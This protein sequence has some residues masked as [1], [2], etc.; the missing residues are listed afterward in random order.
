M[1]WEVCWLDQRLAVQCGLQ[2]ASMPTT[3]FRCHVHGIWS[4]N[5]RLYTVS[6]RL[7]ELH[8]PSERKSHPALSLYFWYAV[9]T[10]DR[11]AESAVSQFPCLERL[12]YGDQRTFTLKFPWLVLWARNG[13]KSTGCGLYKFSGMG[14]RSRIRGNQ[15][16]RRSLLKGLIRRRKIA[17]LWRSSYSN[18]REGKTLPQPPTLDHFQVS[19]GFHCEPAASHDKTGNE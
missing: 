14:S 11:N 17:V 1:I 8:F 15:N 7:K 16:L 3:A 12:T 10:V 4:A 2:T 9:T 6:P 18:H 19:C 13:Q 5:L